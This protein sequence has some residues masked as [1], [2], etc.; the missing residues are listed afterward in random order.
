MR[1]AKFYDTIAGVVPLGGRNAPTRQPHVS[2]CNAAQT[3]RSD[4]AMIVWY[5][6][7]GVVNAMVAHLVAQSAGAR[8]LGCI[9]W[10]SGNVPSW[11]DRVTNVTYVVEVGLA[12]FG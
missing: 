8:L 7:R 11:I 12:E 1:F 10:A 3:E 9:S 6:E 4:L 5:G 2:R